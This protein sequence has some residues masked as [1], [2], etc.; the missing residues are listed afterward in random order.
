MTEGTHYVVG[1]LDN[2][3]D[4]DLVFLT[5]AEADQVALDKS[6]EETDGVYAVWFIENGE[7][8]TVALAF[9]ERIWRPE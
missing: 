6:V 3:S 1:L 5:Q 4:D 9:E 7:P 2:P 8:T